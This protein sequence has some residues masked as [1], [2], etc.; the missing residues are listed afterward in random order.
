M[1]QIIKLPQL[2]WHGVKDLEISF[3]ESW[4]IEMCNMGGYDRPALSPAQIRSSIRFPIGIQPIR[5]LAKGK[6][7]VAIIFDDIQRSTRVADIVPF[8]IEELNEAGITDDHIRFIGATGL[9]A[10]MDRSIL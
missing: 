2:S 10:A 9:H 6:K 4:K 3:P 1:D 8:L 7:E 5:E